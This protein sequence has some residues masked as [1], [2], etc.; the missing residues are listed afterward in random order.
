MKFLYEYR[1]SDNQKHKGTLDAPDRESAFQVLKS[2]GIR[3]SVVKEAP[4]FFNQWFGKGKRWT[5]IIFLSLLS[6]SLSVILFS[7]SLRDLQSRS[8]PPSPYASTQGFALPIERRQ[9]WGDEA[10]VRHG[11]AT[12]WKSLFQSPAEQ[13]LALFAQPGYAEEVFPDFP[14]EDAFFKEEFE[15][16]LF[17]P[18]KIVPGD[19][20][21]YQQMKAMVT[22]MKE[23]LRDYLAAGGT[24][25][26][27]LK[28]LIDRQRE[29]SDFVTKAKKELDSRIQ[30]GDD[31]LTAWQE[32]N[33]TLRDQGLKSIPLPTE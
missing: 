20:D 1:T 28:R 29:E 14:L 21:E 23:E 5:L 30:K 3:P 26:G 24:V 11:Q 32:I 8:N 27:Y 12:Q 33:L 7:P 18:I 31:P 22:G 2:R 13:F 16:I 19:L 9:I 4:G 15:A 6:L 17:H 10:V 25:D